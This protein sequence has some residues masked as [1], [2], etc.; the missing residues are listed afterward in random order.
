MTR[1]FLKAPDQ[2]QLR[3]GEAVRHALALLVERTDFRDPDLAETRLTV[4]EVRVSPDL[5]NAVVFVAPLGGGDPEQALAGLKRVCS[6]LRYELARLVRLQFVPDLSF[7][8]DARFDAASYI[9]AILRRSDVQRDLGNGNRTDEIGEGVGK[10]ASQE[11]L[12]R[13]DS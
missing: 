2:R 5:H 3:V 13:F 11:G 1:H 10:G 9:E 6:F 8:A 4:T 7:R 12:P